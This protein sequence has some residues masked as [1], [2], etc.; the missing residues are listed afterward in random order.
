M[1][2][3]EFLRKRRFTV[4]MPVFDNNILEVRRKHNDSLKKFDYAIIFSEK[5]S[6]NWINMKVMDILKS[7]GLGREKKVQGQAKL[8]Q[9]LY[10]DEEKR[11]LLISSVEDIIY[12]EANETI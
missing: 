7:P 4:L 3:A 6:I 2:Y 1:K 8:E 11:N 12:G 10:E 9:I 5:A